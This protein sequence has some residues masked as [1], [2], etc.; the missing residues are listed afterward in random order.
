MEQH[1]SLRYLNAMCKIK[2]CNLLCGEF[3]YI[4]LSKL[5][6]WKG[7]ERE[8][9]IL[10]MQQGQFPPMHTTCRPVSFTGLF[11]GRCTP[12]SHLDRDVAANHDVQVW[13]RMR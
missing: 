3:C 6:G 11:S 8:A 10:E 5:D 1:S 9:S 4:L 12:L 13:P 2:W 7:M